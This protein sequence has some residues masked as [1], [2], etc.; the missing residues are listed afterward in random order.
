M[1]NEKDLQTQIDALKKRLDN[2]DAAQTIP[3]SVDLAWK[4]RGFVKT[5]FFVAGTGSFNVAGEYRLVIPGSDKN[6]IA[7]IT[8]YPDSTFQPLARMTQAYA[9]NNYGAS[10]TRFDITNPAGTTFRYTYDGTGT[11]PNINSTTVPVGS[12]MVIFIGGNP[13]NSNAASRPY[14]VVTGSGANYFE[15]DNSVGVAENNVTI[16]SGGSIIGGPLTQTYG[17]YALGVANEEFAFV[18]FLFPKL[19]IEN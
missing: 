8:G 10:S 1:N 5:D 7:L 12:Q 13:L 4:N 2:F 17:L 18:V 14:F 3:L 11:D 9:S 19:Y 6:S 16:G 15:V